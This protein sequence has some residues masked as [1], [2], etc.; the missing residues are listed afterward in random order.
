MISICYV[1]IRLATYLKLSES[2]GGESKMIFLQESTDIT[3]LKLE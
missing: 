3:T 2:L 1:Q